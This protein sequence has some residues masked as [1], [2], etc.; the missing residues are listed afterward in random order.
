MNLIETTLIHRIIPPRHKD[1]NL[2]PALILLHGR[3]TDE[4]DLLGLSEY[5]DDRFLCISVRAPFPFEEGGGYTWYDIID[6][7]KPEPV[8][9]AE[10]YRKLKQFISHAIKDYPIDPKG[11][12]LLGFSMGS[13]MSY[14]LALTHPEL[15][16]GVVANSGYIPEESEPRYRWSNI[17]KLPFY[18]SHG[19]YD[20]VIPVQFGREAADTLKKNNALVEYHEY[21]MGHEISE[22]SLHDMGLWLTGQLDSL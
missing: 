5:L 1:S 12:Y 19:I 10:S 14:T 4:N 7:G 11:I 22:E 9:Q 17:G 6:I 18:V 21:P 20:P 15:F 13:M 3:G 16:R 8:M 2:N